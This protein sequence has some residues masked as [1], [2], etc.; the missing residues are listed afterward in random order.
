LCKAV[1]GRRT[2]RIEEFSAEH[3][4]KRG[5]RGM[6][7]TVIGQSA[8]G[9]L[10]KEGCAGTVVTKKQESKN[11]DILPVTPALVCQKN[12]YCRK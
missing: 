7:Y 2:E 11:F 3:E 9:Y 6:L 1:A 4:L 12:D 10:E 5:W 8:S